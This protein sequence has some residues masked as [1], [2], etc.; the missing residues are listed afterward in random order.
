MSATLITCAS[1]KGP[2]NRSSFARKNSTTIRATPARIIQRAN[3]LPC[4]WGRFRSLHNKAEV[5]LHQIN[6][7][8]GLEILSNDTGG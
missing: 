7:E 4:A 5:L 1:V 6:H 2:K 3:R 8:T